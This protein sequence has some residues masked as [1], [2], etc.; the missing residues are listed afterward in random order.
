MSDLFNVL[1]REVVVTWIYLN[2]AFWA[3]FATCASMATFIFYGRENRLT[4][5]VTLLQGFSLIGLSASLLTT[6]LSL[7]ITSDTYIVSAFAT[8]SM[9]SGFILFISK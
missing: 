2:L 6:L 9:I 5:G 7:V 8:A 4:S 3:V 1:S